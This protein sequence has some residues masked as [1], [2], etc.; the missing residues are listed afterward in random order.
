MFSIYRDGFEVLYKYQEFK[1][2]FTGL[3]YSLL[4]IVALLLIVS[5]L[6]IAYL[7]GFNSPLYRR[8]SPA[9][10]WNRQFFVA[11]LCLI[12]LTGGFYWFLG[13]IERL[14]S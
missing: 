6:H 7:L 10:G 12:A 3:R 14:V 4:L 5:L 13:Y 1:V 2:V 8:K 11:I 9:R